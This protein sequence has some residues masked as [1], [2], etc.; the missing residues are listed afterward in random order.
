MP[1]KD[2]TKLYEAQKRHRLKVRAKMFEFLSDKSCVDCGEKDP[3]VLEFDHKDPKDK[4]K[5][6]GKML[7]G[8]YS[9]E[10]VE[11]EIRKCEIR[12]A[13]CHRRKTYI[14]FKCFGRSKPS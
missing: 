13:N 10:S 14:Q 7:S 1:Y 3:I 9:W 5:I 4:F 12:C 8:H 11:K 6:I 2:R